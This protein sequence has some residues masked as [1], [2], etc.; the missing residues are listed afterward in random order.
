MVERVQ[1]GRLQ[2][3]KILFDFVNGEALPGTA[4]EPDQFWT[5][6]D[7]I[8]HDLSP[9]N[10]ELLAKRDTLQV[11]IDA[12]H[13]DH[14]DTQFDIELYKSFLKEIGYLLPEGDDFEASTANVDPEF[15]TIAGPQ[16]V[17]PVT[18]ARYAL[19]AAN[20]RWGH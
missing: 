7:D 1:S 16:L 5:A 4:V 9:R 18:N 17:V 10:R 2:V 8:V 19:N 15:A 12:W 11:Q 14:R 20:A 13:K 3:A 6:F